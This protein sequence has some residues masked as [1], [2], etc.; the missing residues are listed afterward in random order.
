MK[1]TDAPGHSGDFKVDFFRPL[2]LPMKDVPP[3]VGDVYKN[4]AGAFR[5]AKR[6]WQIFVPI[7]L[8][9]ITS[10]LYDIITMKTRTREL[11]MND[12]EHFKNCL[13]IC[14]GDFTFQEAVSKNDSLVLQFPVKPCLPFECVDV[15]FTVRSYWKNH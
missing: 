6:T 8:R 11:L 14:V 4:T 5:D 3:A 12:T 7:P 15:C 2:Y 10:L 1:G 9:R 13:R